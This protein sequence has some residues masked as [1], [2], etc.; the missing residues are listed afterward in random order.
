[1]RRIKQ[2][3]VT[4]LFGKFKHVIP[5]N[6]DE[7]MTII[8]G[9]NGFGKTFLLKMLNGLFSSKYY[10]LC[11]IPFD[12]FR[13]DFD[14]KSSILVERRVEQ[15][16]SSNEN[17]VKLKIGLSRFDKKSLSFEINGDTPINTN[18]YLQNDIFK[19][20]KKIYSKYFD[21]LVKTG[22]KGELEEWKDIKI[23]DRVL[24]PDIYNE[25]KWWKNYKNYTSIHFIVTQRL[26][27][28][29][30]EPTVITYSEELALLIKSTLGKY[31]ELAQS[32]DKIFPARLLSQKDSSNSLDYDNLSVDELQKELKELE[33]KRSRL[34]EIGLL[35]KDHEEDFQLPSHIDEGT[36]NVLAIY[37][38]DTDKKLGVFDELADKLEMLKKII[39]E[40]FL[41][42]Q[43]SINKKEGFI[44]MSSDGNR[45]SPEKLSS[46]EQ[47]ELVLIYELLFKVQPDSLILIDE[48][49]L[50]LHV[51][52]QIQFLKDL[53]AIT[54]LG[55]FDV[56][57]ATH[58][59]QIIDD[60]WDLTVE[61]RE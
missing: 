9:P 60:R 21:N 10:L 16:S 18:D 49:E 35:D 42:K 14:D 51:A 3:A 1:M 22:I 48:P 33:E 39:N 4:N 19:L 37:I 40:R 12:E 7:R 31:A 57:I 26:G 44:F 2:I 29:S 32:L 25:P 13:V 54:I 55:S 43:I 56:L 17:D 52:W 23:S 53:H 30:K 34:M 47:H 8:H 6:M 20:E 36:K 61:L 27:N 50:S 28:I 38:Q 46:G 41:Y 59:P 15:E 45:L 11:S 58:S 24:R 5:L